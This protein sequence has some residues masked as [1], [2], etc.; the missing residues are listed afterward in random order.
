MRKVWK[1]KFLSLGLGELYGMDG[2]P[3]REV[4]DRLL[5]VNRA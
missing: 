4:V 5:T 2:M 3:R 1:S